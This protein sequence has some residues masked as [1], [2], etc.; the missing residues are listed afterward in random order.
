MIGT[1]YFVG[2]IA[3]ST[4][5][6]RLADVYGRKPFVVIGGFLQSICTL[7]LVYSY[8]LTLVYVNMFIFGISSPFL[9]SIGYNYIIELIPEVMENP[10]NTVIM[11]VDGCGSLIG[12]IYFTYLS[13]DINS[14]LIVISVLGIISSIFHLLTPE[15]PVFLT[16]EG[17]ELVEEVSNQHDYE[18]TSF[19][20]F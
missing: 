14:F 3:G 1:I 10:I 8:S 2:Y 19:W 6:P 16:K 4:Y 20:D 12:I 15:S 13:S 7:A 5:F 11:I 9:S 17:G 18:H